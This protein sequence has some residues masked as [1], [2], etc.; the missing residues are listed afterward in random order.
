MG[1]RAWALRGADQGVLEARIDGE[2][3]GEIIVAIVSIDS[4]KLPGLNP[5]RRKQTRVVTETLE[6]A[7]KDRR[8]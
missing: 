4:V 1:Q 3:T 5:P 8:V 6:K 7:W 2:I